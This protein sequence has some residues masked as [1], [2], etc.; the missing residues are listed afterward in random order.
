MIRHLFN[1]GV[2]YSDF[3]ISSFLGNKSEEIIERLDDQAKGTIRAMVLVESARYNS[4]TN[5]EVIK[6]LGG[7]M[8]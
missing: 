8:I 1:D 7:V 2:N 3:E 4:L 6:S 5:D